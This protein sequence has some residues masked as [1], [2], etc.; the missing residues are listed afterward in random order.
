MQQVVTHPTLAV[1]QRERLE[2]RKAA[3]QDVPAIGRVLSR[4]FQD[5][6]TMRWTIPDDTRRR[7]IL[8]GLFGFLA[9]ALQRH[10]ETYVAGDGIG[11]ALWVP[12]GKQ[13]VSDAEAAELAQ[14]LEVLA[15]S[16]ATRLL[17]FM[18]LLDE[19]HPHGAFYFL[20][21]LAVAPEWQGR[22]IGSA[23]MAPVLAPR[24]GGV[25]G[26]P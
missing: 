8:P 15:G 20:N 22:G 3:P 21:L 17:E 24:S 18:A 14:R 13:P 4:A 2:I 23:L 19:H 10:E 6:P 9:A 11:A 26:I 5:D 12:P 7:R 1:P 25:A 16:E